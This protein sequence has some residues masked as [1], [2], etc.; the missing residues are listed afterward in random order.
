[1]SVRLTSEIGLRRFDIT[2]K[3]YNETEAISKFKLMFL[4]FYSNNSF[5]LSIVILTTDFCITK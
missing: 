2:I 1:M 4:F 5:N 3:E